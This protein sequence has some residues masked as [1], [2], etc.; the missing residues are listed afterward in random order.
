MATDAQ[1]IQMLTDALQ[2][3]RASSK[4]PEI[5]AFDP[6]NIDLWIKRVDNAYRRANITDPKD[7]FAFLETKFAVDIDPCINSFI[8][9]DGTEETWTE[10]NKYLKE[11]YGRTK[12]QRAAVVL[13]GVRREGRKPSEMFAHILE[14][15]GELT[16]DDIVKEMVVREL[17]TEVQR[18]IHDKSQNLSGLETVKLADTFFDKDGKPVHRSAPAMVSHVDD[19]PGLADTTDDEADGVNALGARPKSRPRRLRTNQPA[20]HSYQPP[21]R[22]GNAPQRT[23][24]RPRG[25]P[26]FTPAFNNFNGRPGERPPTS[27]GRQPTTEKRENSGA[28]TVR[29]VKLC[30]KHDLYGSNAHSCEPGCD[31]YQQWSSNGKA[32]RQA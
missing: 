29:T 24:N 9:G 5:P 16:V 17:P 10:F 12:Q 27:G 21:Q 22:S 32:G 14:R 18:V 11:R 19:V 28:P 1:T 30:K 20:Q 3:L 23:N 8:F 26:W 25:K 15:I 7:K 31:K 13:D 6:K 2:G 4:K